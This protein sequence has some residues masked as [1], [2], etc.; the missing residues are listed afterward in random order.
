MDV[1]LVEKPDTSVTDM[2]V[3][4]SFAAMLE[5]HL[6]CLRSASEETVA[7][8]EEVVMLGFQQCV[9]YITKVRQDDQAHRLYVR[10]CVKIH[11]LSYKLETVRIIGISTQN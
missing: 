6:S 7:V 1:F 11:H 4:V 10:V 2:R 5:H 9:Y 8:L 3:H